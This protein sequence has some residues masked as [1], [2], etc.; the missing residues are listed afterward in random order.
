MSSGAA[1]RR[2]RIEIRGDNGQNVSMNR[3]KTVLICIFASFIISGFLNPIGLISGPVAESFGIP[4]TVAVA[5]FGYFTV[6]VFAG[7]ILSFYIFD[8]V[9][10]KTVVVVGYVLVAASVGGLYSFPTS[11]ALAIFLFMIGLLASVQVC[12]ASTL[13]SWIWSGKP[14]Q[15]ML[16]AQDAMF[17]GGGIVFTTITTWFLAANYH[18]ASTYAVVAA[19]ALLIAGIAATAEVQEQKDRDEETRIRTSWNLGILTVGGSILLFMIAKISVF[20][21]A[22]QFVEQAFGATIQ[23]SGRLLT[24]IFIGAF[25]G[26]LIGTYVV[27]RVR[28]EYF[29]IAM[30]SLGATGLSLTIAASE[31]QTTL[32]AGYLVGGSVGATFN[33]YT[34]FGLSFVPTPTHK[35]VAYLLLAG[36]T[37]SAIA[38]WFSSQVVEITGKVHDALLAC[39]VIQ[40]VVLVTVLLLTAYSRRRRRMNVDVVPDSGGSL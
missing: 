30:L 28:I 22:P 39:L 20:I 9:K 2:T 33:A 17:N 31:L 32:L 6:G 1:V 16:I 37:G 34:A 36:G 35:N 5:R 12:G 40:G 38:P 29:L 24:N 19:L 11:S 23:Q 18:W 4:I 21:W 25:C 8:Y 15:T 3:V 27:S 26:S 14:R 10:L 7:Y 13:V